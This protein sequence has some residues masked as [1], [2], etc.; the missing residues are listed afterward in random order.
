MLN[1]E[2]YVH[3]YS[4]YE[5]TRLTDQANTLNELL[6][7]D[8]I[9]PAGSNVLEIGCGVGAQTE[10]LCKLNPTINLTSVDISKQSLNQAKE[11]CEKLDIRNVKFIHADVYDLP[12]EVETFDHVFVCFFLEHLPDP[13]AAIQKLKV[14]IRPRGTVSV[15]EGDHGSAYYYPES[16]FAQATINC[17][18]KLQAEHGGNSL[19]GRSLYPFLKKNHFR[20]ISV[21]PRM[22]YADAGNPAMVEGFTRKTFIAMVEG[23]RK[24]AIDSKLISEAEWQNGIKDLYRSADKNG[25]FCYTFFKAK[26][27]I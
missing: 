20:E 11:R 7:Y 3:G 26:A 25:V 21:S 13:D 17:L 16:Q 5:T 27:F 9:F 23:I 22:I 4:D 2:K 14:L 6:H 1:K 18:I 10:I 15:I 8:S 12:F 19:I 24:Q